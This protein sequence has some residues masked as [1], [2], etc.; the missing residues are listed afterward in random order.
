MIVWV[1]D[2]QSSALV[3]FLFIFCSL[4]ETDRYRIS[5]ET[6]CAEPLNADERVTLCQSQSCNSHAQH[7][8]AE[9]MPEKCRKSKR[10]SGNKNTNWEKLDRS[11]TDRVVVCAAIAQLD[12]CVCV[13]VCCEKRGKRDTETGLCAMCVIY[14]MHLIIITVQDRDDAG[15]CMKEVWIVYAYLVKLLF[16]PRHTVS[17]S[18]RIACK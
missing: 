11:R 14:V 12:E 2:G 17:L 16:P 4:S 6:L 10:I 5:N 8:T 9:S 13:C 15:K 1:D 3:V 7:T 18:I